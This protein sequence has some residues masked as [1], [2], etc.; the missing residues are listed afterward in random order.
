M[1]VCVCTYQHLT[2]S[3]WT[4]LI[5]ILLKKQ[6]HKCSH[7]IYLQRFALIQY[8]DYDVRITKYISTNQCT[9]LHLSICESFFFHF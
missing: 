4:F 6:S 2:I 1:C 9:Y 3:E 5:N 8:N 7:V